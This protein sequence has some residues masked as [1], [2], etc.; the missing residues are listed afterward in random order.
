[1][2]LPVWR[3]ERVGKPL[4][5]EC[6]HYFIEGRY[7]GAVWRDETSCWYAHCTANGKYGHLGEFKSKDEAET[8]L[9]SEIRP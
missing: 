7:V 6:Y 2:T 8:K 3:I 9:G 4:T 5:D 1:M